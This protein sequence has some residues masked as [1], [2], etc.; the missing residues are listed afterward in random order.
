MLVLMAAVTV[1][2][3]SARAEA[4]TLDRSGHTGQQL[5]QAACV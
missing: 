4:Q 1:L 3:L 5:Y 2:V